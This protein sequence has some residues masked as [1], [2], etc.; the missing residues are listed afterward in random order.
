MQRAGQ[1]SLPSDCGRP[2]LGARRVSTVL[3]GGKGRASAR[4]SVCLAGPAAGVGDL[5]PS[6]LPS[7][8]TTG[9]AGK[10]QAQEMQIDEWREVDRDATPIDWWELR[11]P[12]KSADPGACPRPCP[13]G[14]QAESWVAFSLPIHPCLHKVQ[15][16]LPLEFPP[17]VTHFSLS[18][19]WASVLSS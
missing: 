2:R 14:S 13:L 12:V 15:L 6:P 10:F 17:R 18:D 4:G 5:L 1:D 7:R 16:I 9:A 3:P 8:A 11:L 19:A